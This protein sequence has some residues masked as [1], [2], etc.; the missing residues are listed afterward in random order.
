MSAIF[1]ILRFDDRAVSAADLERMGATMP[2]RSPDRRKF[3]IHGS[4]G[5]GH[6]LMRVTHEDWQDYQPLRDKAA[7][8]S[9]VADARLD[10]REELAGALGIADDVLRDLADGALILAAYK[11][12][13]EDLADHLLGDF[14]FALWDGAARKLVLVRDHMGQRSL[15]YTRQNGFFA[16]ATEIKA[17]WAVEGVP[18]GLSDAAIARRL[19][20]VPP[21]AGTTMFQ[22]VFGLSSATLSVV[23]ENGDQT[24]RRYW[25]PHAAAAHEGRDEGYYIDTYRKLMSEA[26]ACRLRRTLRPAA[27]LFSGGFD[28]AAIAGLAGP[29]VEAQGRKLICV[30]AA[31]SENYQGPMKPPGAEGPRKDVRRWVEICRRHMSHL[32]IRYVVR[33]DETLLTGL[34]EHFRLTDAPAPDSHHVQS[35]LYKTA[36][37]AGARVIMDGHGGDYTVNPKDFALPAR[38]LRQ[39]RL[40]RFLIEAFAEARVRKRPRW[41]TVAKALRLLVP[42]HVVRA[43]TWL[44]RGGRA[45]WRSR[46]IART[47]AEAILAEGAVSASQLRSRPQHALT[48]RDQL[49]DI[50]VNQSNSAWTPG[51]GSAPRGLEFTRPFHD[52]R[53]VEFALAVP[54]ALYVRDGRSRYLACRA[55]AGVLPA[56]FQTRA[57]GENDWMDPDV[58]EM[59]DGIRDQLVAEIDRMQGDPTLNRYIDFERVRTLLVAGATRPAGVPGVRANRALNDA[60][61]SFLIARQIQWFDQKNEQHTQL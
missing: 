41:R 9:L 48:P 28:S 40:V 15:F 43:A 39:G 3:E 2:H 13:G 50:L 24:L 27:L 10:N 60:L 47:F 19:M 5:V 25:Q 22:D 11:R 30:S 55:L 36:A 7:N 18:R 32:D 31:L 45:A 38:L 46:P 26:V 35:A 53:I 20:L 44:H 49:L 16:F 56:A 54:K 33:R 1:G 52:K 12:W 6:G 17:L 23:T 21:P 57:W 37:A 51:L 34:E 29:V 4:V 14:A 8:L 42:A 58:H 61:R 59:V